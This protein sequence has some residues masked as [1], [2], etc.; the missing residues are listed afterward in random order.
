MS[1]EPKFA[2][3]SS[4]IGFLRME[5]KD[6]RLSLLHILE[7]QPDSLGEP[8]AFMDGVF[9]QIIEYIRGSRKSF[10]IEL[11][12]SSCTDF[13][14]SVLEQLRKIPYGQT[15][16]YKQIATATGN[17]KASRAV[18]MAN[19]RN[20]IHIIIPCHRVIGARGALTGYA[21]GIDIKEFLLNIERLY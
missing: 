6:G 2:V 20:P 12:I 19:N 11:D 3:Y 21:A 17:P 14:R 9:D 7:S 16:T 18:G 1:A 5:H 4:P 15:R 8:D 10:D 13:Q